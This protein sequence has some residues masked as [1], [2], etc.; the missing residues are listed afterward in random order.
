MK[1]KLICSAILAMA[2]S[3][4]AFAQDAA[5]DLN[6]PG[7]RCNDSLSR[8]ARF[9][10]IADNTALGQWM[11]ERKACFDAGAG[12]RSAHLR[13]EEIAYAKSAFVFQQMA[14]ARSLKGEGL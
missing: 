14:I 7:V 12:F 8:D 6:G 9:E 5:E 3:F 10:G 11:A 13:P 4:G 2:A 1:T